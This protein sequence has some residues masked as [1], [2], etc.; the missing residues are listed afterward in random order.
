MKPALKKHRLGQT[1]TPRARTPQQLARQDR[2]FHLSVVEGKS[3]R[4]IAKELGCDKD[5]VTDDIRHE[6][7][8]RAAELDDAGMRQTA[9]AQSVAVYR[10]V[11]RLALAKGARYDQVVKLITGE[12][13]VDPETE[14][15][16][17]KKG[18]GGGKASVTDRTLGDIVAAQTRIDKL[19]GVDAPTRV[20]LGLQ[21]LIDALG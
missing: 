12:I 1:G 21:Q 18:T 19:L 9:K 10:H 15:E 4:E 6:S 17:Q 8:R 20:D 7:E 2:A 16:R 13:E 3:Y 14:A 5:T 11:I